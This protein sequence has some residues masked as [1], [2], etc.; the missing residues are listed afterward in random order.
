ML[1]PSRKRKTLHLRMFHSPPQVR[2][3]QINVLSHNQVDIP[4]EWKVMN[5]EKKMSGSSAIEKAFHMV[6]RD[7]LHEEIARM[8]Y[9]ATLP[10]H[11]ARNLYYFNAPFCN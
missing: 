4:L 11:L 6:S 7:H 9:L 2:V 10:F 3:V 1:M 5:L 8:F